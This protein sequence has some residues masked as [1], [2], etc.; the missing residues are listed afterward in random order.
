MTKERWEEAVAQLDRIE[1]YFS[2]N[3][4]DEDFP[5]DAIWDAFM[6]MPGE[7]QASDNAMG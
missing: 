5:T 6:D 4:M 1:R 3:W 7:D 2:K